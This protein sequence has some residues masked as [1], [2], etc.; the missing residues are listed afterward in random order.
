[1]ALAQHISIQNAKRVNH[2][3]LQKTSQTGTALL[4]LLWWHLKAYT[5]V[6]R[7]MLLTFASLGFLYFHWSR[8]QLIQLFQHRTT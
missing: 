6:F 7:I 1:M 4:K 3:L 8:R 2:H 5:T